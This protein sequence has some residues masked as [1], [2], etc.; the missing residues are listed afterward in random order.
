MTTQQEGKCVDLE[1][2]APVGVDPAPQAPALLRAAERRRVARDLAAPRVVLVV[3]DDPLARRMLRAWLAPAGYQVETASTLAE[4]ELQLSEK[5]V[6]LV[7][8]DLN[9]PEGESYT[10]CSRWSGPEVELPVLLIS[11][12]SEVNTK[13]RAFEA[14]AVDF[15]TKP[16][17]GAEVL[18]RVKTHLRLKEVQRE[19]ADLQAER[20]GHLAQAQQSFMPRAADLPDANFAVCLR[21]VLP[22]G[23][24]FYDVIASG[25]STTDYIVADVSGHDL[26]TSLWTAAFKALVSEF[27]TLS[28][29]P[30]EI[31]QK[32]NLSLRKFVPKPIYFTAV[33]AR[34]DR[35]AGTLI[36]ANAA[37]PS[38]LVAPS[39]GCA[40][41]VEQ[42]G[43]IIGVF[44]DAVFDTRERRVQPGDRLYLYTDGL[45]EVPDG[46]DAGLSRLMAA[47]D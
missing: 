14:G 19:L 32:V 1:D 27:A 42:N 45:I 12:D 40:E 28:H 22:A 13:V 17:A 18:A 7:L 44:A 6:E 39:G 5:P 36:V 35:A 46:R 21:P 20:L 26:G 23:G 16:L 29:S 11:A 25:P 9:L 38:A 31:L 37:H 3:D 8:L 41:R 33:L 4:A 47:C 24:D 2:R 15:L 34:L 10:F 30:V 43:D